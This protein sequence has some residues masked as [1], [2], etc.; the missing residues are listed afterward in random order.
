MRIH[1]ILKSRG[2][3]VT[4]LVA[5]PMIVWASKFGPI[6]NSTGA[7]GS[8]RDACAKSGCHVGTALNAGE[9]KVE[10]VF[11]SGLTYAAGEK[12]RI[13]VVITDPAARAY[14]FQVT[15]RVASNEERDQAGTFSTVGSNQIV[16]C[17]RDEERRGASCPANSPLEF[18]EHS[19]SSTSNTFEIDW[20]PPANASVGAVSFFVAANAA[21]GNTVE[22]GDKIYAAK[23]TLTPKAAPANAPA[24]T[25]SNGVTNG[26]SFLPGVVTGAWTT[27]FGT[28]LSPTTRDWSGAIDGQG[29]FP[30]ALDGVSVT[31]DGKPAY[32]YYA[33][34]GQLN[35]QVP[36]LAGK[37]GPIP[38][39]VK[40]PA[41]ESAAYSAIAAKELPGL[42]T[43]SLNAKP[44]PAA[45]RLDGAI[46]GP[47]ATSG[48]VP[49]KPGET[50]LFF[51]T[52]F[53][54]TNPAVAP[55]KMFSGA[56]HMV[57]S[58]VMRIG[59]VSVTPAFAGLS[60]SG[61]NQFNVTIPDLPNGEH[62]IEMSINSVSIQTGVL[63]PVQR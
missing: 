32:I 34:P 10:L 35:V 51:G 24:I 25:S 1:S 27:V 47:S 5:L 23:Y 33:S 14:G 43:Y 12:Q 49:A 4:V 56:A 55:G 7:P 52:G 53:G 18:I 42:F 31:F 39:V 40:T 17:Q 3:L 50:I 6:A 2:R 37:T 57:D 59:G 62:A 46:V 30:T 58:V 36:D 60:S 41:G 44:Y 28:N 26:A 45:V 48:V 20:T 22:T 21:N 8:N 54:P 19:N 61:L 16:V 9:G 13:K 15:A 63:L 38:V 11:P 29:N